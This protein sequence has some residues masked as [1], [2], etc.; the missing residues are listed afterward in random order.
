MVKVVMPKAGDR[1]TVKSDFLNGALNGTGTVLYVASIS[2]FHPFAVELDKPC[3]DGHKIY[4]FTSKEVRV[5]EEN[6]G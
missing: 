4:R 6:R 2:E 1:V 3:G 5:I